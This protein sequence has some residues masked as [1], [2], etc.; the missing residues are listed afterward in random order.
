MTSRFDELIERRGTNSIKWDLYGDGVLPMWVADADYRSPDEVDA[1]LRA[2]LAQGIFGY[3]MPPRAMIETVVAR[4]GRL[5]GWTITP[6]DVITIPGIVTGLFAT[7]RAY[8]HAGDG[9]LMQPPVYPPFM[10]A[11]RGFGLTVDNA[12]LVRQVDGQRLS[13]GIDFDAF[14]R[15]ITP[16]TRILMLCHPHNPTGQIYSPDELRRMAEIATRHDLIIVSD[17]IHSELLLG[18]ATL[19]PMAVAAP[20][21]VNRLVTFVAPTKTFN[22]AGLGCGFAIIQDRRLRTQFNA[23]A[24]GIVPH[25]SALSMTAAGA[26]YGEATDGW[27]AELREHLTGNRDALVAFVS[28]RLPGVLTTAPAATYLAWLDFSALNLQPDPHKFLLEKARVG[29]IEGT[30]FGP[31]GA[32]H[33][34]LNFA[35]PRSRLMDGLEQIARAV[36]DR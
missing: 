9:I 1:A 14:E 32:G 34:R 13:Y 20:E 29:L 3:E 24:E 33:V 8:G 36:E 7:A 27:L 6:E 2:K 10:S 4:M 35:C 30:G 18:G 15:A 11:A 12:P 21:A 19:T 5:Y 16:R 28:E 17:E 23:A 25:V 26:A 22:L 31:G